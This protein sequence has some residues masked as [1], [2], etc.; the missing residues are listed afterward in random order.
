M[1][2]SFP[3]SNAGL[4]E[5]FEFLSAELPGMARAEGL[6]HRFAVIL[7]EI[8]ANM[9]RHD[10]SLDESTEF[11]LELA[12]HGNGASLV[13]SDPGHPFDPL[14]FRHKEQPEIGGHGIT[15][16]K[17]LSTAVRYERC[18]DRNRLTIIIDEA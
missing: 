16:V 12:P 8:C 2:R 15:L 6:A 14:A 7:D 17:G 5:A 9:I 13:I 18:G 3:V 10:I 1:R 4:T 11:M